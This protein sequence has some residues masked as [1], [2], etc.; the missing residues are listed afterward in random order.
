MSTKKSP[1]KW[2]NIKKKLGFH[3]TKTLTRKLTP[4]LEPTLVNIA[5]EVLIEFK[6][7]LLK[8]DNIYWPVRASN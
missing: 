8:F 4:N 1:D 7:Y 2:E 5:N 3:R 6:E